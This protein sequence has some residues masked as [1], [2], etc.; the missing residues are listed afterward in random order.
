M[1][2]SQN[3]LTVEIFSDVFLMCLLY[4]SN[5]YLFLERSI[6]SACLCIILDSSI[7]VLWCKHTLSCPT[8]F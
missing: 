3:M 6:C 4:K 1:Y 8:T 2:W 5:I 7:E